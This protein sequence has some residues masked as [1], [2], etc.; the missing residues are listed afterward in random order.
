MVDL[1]KVIQSV[2]SFGTTLQNAKLA[3]FK[4]VLH[5]LIEKNDS[6]KINFQNYNSIWGIFYYR[7]YIICFFYFWEAEEHLQFI[8]LNICISKNRSFYKSSKCNSSKLFIIF[9]EFARKV[10]NFS[11]IFPTGG[12]TSCQRFA[13]I[14]LKSFSQS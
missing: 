10:H 2:M 7:C 6:S 1:S 13:K 5:F 8:I 11:K 14:V 3:V 12:I 4:S 9:E